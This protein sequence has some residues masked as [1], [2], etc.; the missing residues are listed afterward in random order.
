MH[1]AFASLGHRIC[2]TYYNGELWKTDAPPEVIYDIF[3]QW[4][5]EKTPEQYLSNVAKTS[6]AH[7]ILEKPRAKDADF[8]FV[9]PKSEG[10]DEPK[11][12]TK[13]LLRKYFTASEP[14]WGPKPRATGAK[15][16]KVSALDG[17]ADLDKS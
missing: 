11:A 9:L 16:A 1:A 13:R 17:A 6:P 3:K 8:D 7:V 2:Q 4:K 5:Q 10:Q 15:K 12:G 14:N